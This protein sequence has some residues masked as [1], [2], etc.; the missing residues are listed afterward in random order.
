MGSLPCDRRRRRRERRRRCR[1]ASAGR[2]LE[3]AAKNKQFS[4]EVA[5][6]EGRK[7]RIGWTEGSLDRI[8]IEQTGGGGRGRVCSEATPVR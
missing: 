3:D 2:R 6:D 1:K 5:L 8:Q 4:R 7:E